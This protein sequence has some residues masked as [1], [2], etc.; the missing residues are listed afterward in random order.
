ML[1]LLHGVVQVVE[2]GIVEMLARSRCAHASRISI[3]R[4]ISLVIL[5]NL[6]T[7]DSATKCFQEFFYRTTMDRYC[8]KRLYLKTPLI[9]TQIMNFEE[10]IALSPLLDGQRS[11]AKTALR[12]HFIHAKPSS[13]DINYFIRS[14]AKTVFIVCWLNFSKSKSKN[15]VVR[16]KF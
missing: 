2:D 15:V 13:G 9:Q 4:F 16:F 3:D 6:P 5:V 14:V 7:S 10:P 12:K 11:S 8:L 1:Y